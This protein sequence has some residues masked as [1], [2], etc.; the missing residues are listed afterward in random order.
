[1]VTAFGSMAAL[2][3]AIGVYGVISYL[4]VLRR[5]ELGVKLALGATAGRIR[6]EVLRWALGLA[7]WGLVLA[8]PV[9]L[10]LSW[11]IRSLLYEVSPFNP[12]IQVGAAAA[13]LLLVILASYGP[14]AGAARI[15][16]VQTLREG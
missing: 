4:V 8:I 11:S 1:V 6:A 10:M 13:I 9:A 16:P 12:V 3:T 7:A 2:L 5:N 14:A 15:D